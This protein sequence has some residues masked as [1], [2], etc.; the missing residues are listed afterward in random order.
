MGTHSNPPTPPLKTNSDLDPFLKQTHAINLTA[1]ERQEGYDVDLL[2]SEPRGAIVTNSKVKGHR[3]KVPVAG[4]EA[5]KSDGANAVPNGEE[6]EELEEKHRLVKPWYLRPLAILIVALIILAIALGIGLGVGLGIKHTTQN[7]V[8][9]SPSNSTSTLLDS[10]PPSSTP[11]SVLSGTTRSTATGIGGVNLTI[12]I[13]TSTSVVNAGTANRPVPSPTTIAS[14][15]ASVLFTS[16]VA[17]PSGESN[18]PIPASNT[19]PLVVTR[20]LLTSAE[21]ARR[22]NTPLRRLK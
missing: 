2:N 18:L 20:T 21:L 11:L 5:E 8:P 7:S 14:G 10:P 17:V 12:I 13:G 3:K 6:G 15:P 1:Q 22:T 16:G 19:I 9:F 4:L